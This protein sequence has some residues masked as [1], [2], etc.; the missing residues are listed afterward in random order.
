MSHYFHDVT[1]PY[2]IAVNARGG[3]VF[4]TSLVSTH[5]G[6]EIR[7]S[8][9]VIAIHQYHIANCRLSQEQ[10]EIFGAFFRVRLGRMYA[11]KMKDY[12]DH[13]INNQT[14]TSDSASQ[15]NIYKTYHDGAYAYNRRITTI[16][17]IGICVTLNDREL[18]QSCVDSER[19]IITLG[20]HLSEHDILKLSCSFYVPVRFD[21]DHFEYTVHPDG[22]VLIPNI[23]LTEVLI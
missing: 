19:G 8:D 2:F 20:R 9:R 13:A 21:H 17:P 18:P 15:I 12:A 16:D 10:F 6:R 11:F 5:S 1:L 4:S 23:R 14:I 3:P 22:S 7:Q